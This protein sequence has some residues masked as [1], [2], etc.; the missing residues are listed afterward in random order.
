MFLEAVHADYPV[1]SLAFWERPTDGGLM[2]M[3]TELSETPVYT[4]GSPKWKGE[5]GAKAFKTQ[6]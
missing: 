4:L 6:I 2:T 1:K 5:R 3:I